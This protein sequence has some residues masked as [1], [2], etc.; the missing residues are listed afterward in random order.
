MTE[1]TY[2]IGAPGAGKSTLMDQFLEGWAVGPYTKWTRKE[3]FGHLLQHPERGLGAYLGHRRPN[4]PGTDALSLSVAPQALL[5][6]EAV[7]L[8]GLSHVYGEGIRLGYPTFL[9]TL[10][11]VADLT[12]VYLDVDPEEASRR[13]LAR[14]GK[15]MSPK[16]CQAATSRAKSCALACQEA[17]IRVVTRQ[18]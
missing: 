14:G 10:S 16:W 1:A 12:V 2:I 4:Y 11:R 5:W 3:M 13:R 17:G 8:L 18:G 7:P 6:A 15:Q 9:I